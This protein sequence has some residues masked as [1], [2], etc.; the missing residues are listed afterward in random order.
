MGRKA[1]KRSALAAVLA[2]A[3]SGAAYAAASGGAFVEPNVHVLQQFSGTQNGATFGWAVSGVADSQKKHFQNALIGEPF[4]GPNFDQGSAH[5]YSS[6]TGRLI[7]RFDG[8]PG[9][10][11]GFSVADAGDVNGDRASDILV[12]A[13]G[14]G[15]AGGPGYVDLYSGL[16]G[17]LLHRFTG[18]AA[19]DSFGWSVSTAGDINGDKHA[20]ILVGAS[21]FAS[22]ANPGRAYIYSGATYALLRTLT[23]DAIGDQFGSAA[24]SVGDVNRDHVPD[25]VIGARGARASDGRPRGRAYVYSGKTGERLFAINASPNGHAFGSFFVAG[26]GDVNGDDVPDIYAADYADSTNGVGAGRAG[27]Y[28][29][30]DGAELLA[31]IG[32]DGAGLGPGRGAGDVNGDGRPDIVVGSYTASDG[33]D[34]AGKIQI[35]SGRTGALLRTITST[36]PGE[37]LG[38]DA[39]GIGDANDDDIPDLLVSAATGERVYIVAG[40][41][42]HENGG[43]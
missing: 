4:T 21:A 27:V 29:G 43:H 41:T 24:A 11:F 36:T 40:V 20:D 39:V 18:E 3:V 34:Q 30:R 17:Q 10:W 1:F 14:G 15:P 16:T 5:L 13:P 38:F 2:L 32:S 6:R 26:V 37:N 19:G 9:D 35:F 25:Q 23:G 28:S 12:G 33:A 8:G 22:G 31:W 7:S 42:A